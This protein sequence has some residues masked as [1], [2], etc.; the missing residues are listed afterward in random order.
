[1]R[2]RRSISTEARFASFKEILL[3]R[4][5]ASAIWSPTRKAGL[6]EVIG[7]WK[8]IASLSPRRSRRRLLQQVFAVEQHLAGGDA[9]RR[10]RDEAHDRERGDALAAARFADDAERAAALEPEVDAVHG[11]HLAALR[12]EVRAQAFDFKQAFC[13]GQSLAR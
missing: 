2:T 1:M 4:I 5:S 13:A 12:G 10:L 3:W 7:S 6:S 11:P 8:I 9:A